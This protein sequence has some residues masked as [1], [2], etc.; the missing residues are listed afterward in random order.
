LVE[1]IY[2]EGKSLSEVLQSN[3]ELMSGLDEYHKWHGENHAAIS[4]K[5]EKP[6]TGHS[7]KDAAKKLKKKK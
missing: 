5:N 4:T 2:D 3:P 6:D 7:V 1:L